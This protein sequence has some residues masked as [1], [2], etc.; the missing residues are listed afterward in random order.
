LNTFSESLRGELRSSGVHVTLLAP[1][2]VRTRI[3]ESV[4]ASAADKLVPNYMW[5]SAEHA[6]KASLD[7]LGRNK[8]RVV[9]GIPAKAMSVANQYL[10]RSIVA[11]IVGRAYKKLAGG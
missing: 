9:P 6:A 2:P 11:P 4:D 5:V 3:L 1:G 8:M 10:P 7:A